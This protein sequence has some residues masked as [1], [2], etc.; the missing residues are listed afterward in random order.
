MLCQV[1][2][3][4]AST[5]AV[6]GK[7]LPVDVGFCLW[8]CPDECGASSV[9]LELICISLHFNPKQAKKNQ[10]S[11]NCNIFT[12][13]TGGKRQVPG[14]QGL[15]SPAICHGV[16][17]SVRINITK[18]S[19][20]LLSTVILDIFPCKTNPLKLHAK[21]KTWHYSKKPCRGKIEL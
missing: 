21:K 7:H 13:L 17:L 11:A 15:K 1:L 18:G 14:W 19:V 3:R 20:H 9:S 16:V 4:A 2:A 5:S 8:L 6:C 12:T 10:R